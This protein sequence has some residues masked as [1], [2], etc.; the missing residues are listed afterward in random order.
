M[1]PVGTFRALFLAIHPGAQV[2]SATVVMVAGMLQP[3]VV[4]QRVVVILEAMT[5]AEV[6]VILVVV[7]PAGVAVILEAVTPAGVMTG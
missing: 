6:A 2:L 3:G 1:A 7:T 5:P 4:T